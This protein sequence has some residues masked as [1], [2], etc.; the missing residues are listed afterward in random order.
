MFDEKKYI[1]DVYGKDVYEAVKVFGEE[2]HIDLNTMYRYQNP[3]DSSILRE[4]VILRGENIHTCIKLE[5]GFR[6]GGVQN[7]PRLTFINNEV[8]N[9]PVNYIIEKRVFGPEAVGVSDALNN[10]CILTADA[11]QIKFWNND[12]INQFEHYYNKQCDFVKKDYD[13]IHPHV[14]ESALIEP[15]DIIAVVDDR[16]AFAQLTEYFKNNIIDKQLTLKK[17]KQ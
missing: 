1:C 11:G 14:F 3:L 7:L 10:R 16:S 9:E 6:S 12:S 17:Q 2:F 5:I 4:S 8:E 13:L 15:D